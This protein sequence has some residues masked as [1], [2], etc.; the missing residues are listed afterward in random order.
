MSETYKA[1]PG[2]E[3]SFVQ[4]VMSDGDV[5]GRISGDA[6]VSKSMFLV[7]F[8]DQYIYCNGP[9]L[10]TYLVEDQE[11]TISNFEPDEQAINPAN[12]YDIYKEGFTFEYKRS[13]EIEGEPVD[14][15]ELVSTDEDADFT[16]IIMYIGQKDSYLKAWDLIDYDGIPTAF[17]VSRF[18]PDKSFPDGYFEFDREKNPVDIETDLRN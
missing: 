8:Q 3:I 16:N 10:W 4:Q 9:I 18:V 2:F 13:D 6:S 12:I 17:E 5:V 1:M 11:L 15:I 7:R 14:V